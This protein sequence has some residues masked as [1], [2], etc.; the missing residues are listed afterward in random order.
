MKFI[1]ALDR[2][3]VIIVTMDD[4]PFIKSTKESAPA[5]GNLEGYTVPM[6]D[7]AVPNIVAF[8][9]E[10]VVFPKAFCSSP[11]CTPSRWSTL[12]GRLGTRN[13][14]AV[15]EALTE[16]PSLGVAVNLK[17]SHLDVG[18]DSIY[19]IPHVLSSNGYWS[20]MVCI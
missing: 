2:P 17:S 10:A 14:G 3:N 5:G 18:L 13:T 20:G 11:K 8:K 1:Q 7:Y 9:N 4:M 16:D 12:T 6:E 15:A 19:N